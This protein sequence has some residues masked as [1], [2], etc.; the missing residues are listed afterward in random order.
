MALRPLRGSER[1][2]LPGARPAGKTEPNE[3][4]EVSILLKRQS[5]DVLGR[6]VA[7]LARGERPDRGRISRA[8]LARTRTRSP[9]FASS[10]PGAVAIRRA[11]QTLGM[12]V[13]DGSG[14]PPGPGMRVLRLYRK[15]EKDT[16]RVRTAFRNRRQI[17]SEV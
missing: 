3:R 15:R 12:T 1:E 10:R 14:V 4:F 8:S 9:Q 5:S 17:T 13:V 16:R 11:L 2:A 7:R 6:H